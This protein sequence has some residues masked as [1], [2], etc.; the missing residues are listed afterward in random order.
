MKLIFDRTILVTGYCVYTLQ[1]NDVGASPPIPLKASYAP[2]HVATRNGSLTFV[3]IRHGTSWR[4]AVCL[5]VVDAQYRSS[6]KLDP[7]R[8][9]YEYGRNPRSRST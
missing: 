6:A 7:S 3:K 2:S 9:A 1:R 5:Y 4:D 8:S